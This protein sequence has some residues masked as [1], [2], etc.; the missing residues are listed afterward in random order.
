MVSKR[1]LIIGPN[2]V[3]KSN[4]LEAV[5]LLCS[6][7]SH[8]C[9]RDQDFIHWDKTE[10]IIA[11]TTKDGDELQLELRRKGG[12]N[13]Y[14][15]HKPLLRQIDLIGPLRCVGFSAL[16]L[17]LVRG[18][19][20]LRRNWLDRVVQ[21]LEPVYSELVG[22]YNKLLRQRRCF[23]RNSREYSFKERSALLDAFDEQMALVST[24][25]HRRR[26]R[27]LAHLEPLAARWQADL[28][29]G[30]ENLRI[31]YGAG[32]VLEGEEEEQVWRVSIEEQLL[33]QREKEERL[34]NCSVGPHRDEI[35]FL[36][37]EALA[38][39]FASAGQQR[40]LVLALKLAELELVGQIY[41]EPP[42]LLL[43]DVLAELDRTRQLLL[44][45]AVGE[46]HQSLITAT[47]LDMFE[48]DWKA[49]SQI[50]EADFFRNLHN[51]R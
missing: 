51:V 23:W 49:D 27:A 29:N 34:G 16:D 6:L 39:R 11:A 17:D 50:I 30:K 48:R 41:G 24:R 43:D 1:L 40:T 36:L 38:R 19:P 14:L 44:L 2:G 32:S 47:H 12:R 35:C 21:Q 26:K 42:L 7:R 37:N 5:E 33:A 28:S 10:S 9:T 25:I 45:E 3:G 13:A 18:E 31:D 20:S 4:L 15:N 22:R 8:R 46:R